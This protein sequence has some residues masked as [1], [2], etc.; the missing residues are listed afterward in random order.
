MKYTIEDLYVGMTVRP[1]DL[2]EIEH[3]WMLVELEGIKGER[4]TLVCF[5]KDENEDD[6][7][8]IKFRIARYLYTESDKQWGLYYYPSDQKKIRNMLSLMSF[9][10]TTRKVIMETSSGRV[11]ITTR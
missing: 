2:N 3:T 5:G 4:G 1:K 7:I 10:P 9:P 8:N 11:V 6:D